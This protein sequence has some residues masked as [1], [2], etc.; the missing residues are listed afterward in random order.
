MNSA[1]LE[2]ALRRAV[3][4]EVRFDAGARAVYSAD[5]SN[6]RQVPIG[7]VLPRSAE[8]VLAA[9]AA[10]RAHGAPVLARGGGTSLCGQ[11]VN[12]AVVLDCSKYMNR[13]LGIDAGARSAR[14]ISVV[15]PL[16]RNPVTTVTGMRLTLRSI[17]G[18]AAA[19]SPGERLLAVRR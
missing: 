2:A 12:V 5:A 19:Q 3:R 14:L 17:G 7:V 9:L 1:E 10:C 4:G 11:T 8:D 13:V 18:G 16:P 15:L 6:Y